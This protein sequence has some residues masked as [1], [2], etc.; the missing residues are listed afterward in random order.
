MEVPKFLLRKK[1]LF[2]SVLFIV[3]FSILFL[4][5]YRPFS[6]AALAVSMRSWRRSI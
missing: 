4:T 1:Y 2:E 6:A 3:L 5:L